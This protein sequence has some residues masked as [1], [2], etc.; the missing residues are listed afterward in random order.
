MAGTG[1][2][3]VLAAIFV[4]AW[5]RHAPERRQ[6]DDIPLGLLKK[7]AEEQPD[8]AGALGRK[9][10]GVR[11]NNPAYYKAFIAWTKVAQ[12]KPGEDG[13]DEWLAFRERYLA[14]PFGN[15]GK[16]N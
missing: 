8:M 11:I 3:C 5:L 1:A 4:W 14:D 13:Y 16:P 12:I 10:L 7:F 9:S 15:G 2:M 6:I